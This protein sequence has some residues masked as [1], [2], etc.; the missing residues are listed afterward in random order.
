MNPTHTASP[1]VNSANS[2]HFTGDARRAVVDTH[3]TIH[4]TVLKES[5]S[6]GTTA[7]RP[8]RSI[9]AVRPGLTP[10]RTTDSTVRN[11]CPAR[12]AYTRATFRRESR[13]ANANT[14]VRG[15]L[16]KTT[17]RLGA[18]S[19]LQMK[20]FRESRVKKESMYSLPSLMRSSSDTTGVGG[21]DVFTKDVCDEEDHP[22]L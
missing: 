5:D 9:H 15:A 19:H 22:G 1:K 8:G 10:N 13:V 7:P 14:R 11:S 21:G 3:I 4:A 20:L 2:C 6:I 17:R 18:T 16:H 12:M